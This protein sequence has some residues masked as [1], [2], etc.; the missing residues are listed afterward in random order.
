MAKKFYITTPI[1][2]A[3]GNLHIGH[4][5]SSTLAWVVRNFKKMQ[6][7]EA[8]MLTGS[9]EHGHKISRLAHQ[10][11]LDPQSFVDKNV[12]KFKILWQKFG[13][14]YDY[15]LRTTSQSHKNFVKKIFYKMHENNDIFQG[16]YQ[17][18]YS[19]SDEEFLSQVQCIEKNNEFFHPVSGAKMELVEENSYFFA[20]SKF[21]KW[22][23]N[24]LDAYPNFISDKKIANELRQNFFQKGLEDLSVSRKNLKWGINLEKFQDQTIYVWLDA[25]FSYLSIFDGQINID[26]PQTENF[27]NQA[28]EIVHVVGKEIARFHCIYWPIFL[29]SLNFRL[30]STIL[31]HGW[32]ITPEGKMSK[33]KGNVIN[34]LE[35]LDEFDPEIIK[36]YFV[37][38]ISTEND[39]IFDKKL[40]E[41]LYNSFFVNTYGNLISR[42]IALVLKYFN[43][44]LKFKIE[45]L[46][47]TDIS[48]YEKILLT[49]DSFSENLSNFQLEKGFK[50]IIELAKNLNGYFDIKQL[51]NEKNLDKLGASLLLVLNGIYTISACLNCVMPKTVGKIIDFLGIK[52]TSF[53]LITKLEKF[54][55]IIFEKLEKPFFPRKKS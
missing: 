24:Y 52:T 13:I 40:L 3:S 38:Q 49:F 18:L 23:E 33:S 19:V 37:S 30:P 9:D 11:G 17:G 50:L 48:Y 53:E 2:Y 15:F 51:W 41:S 54:D 16:Q 5:Y 47:W 22:L 35:L 43:N 10:S 6:G 27:W 8:L 55:N 21:Q 44:G 14:D 25:L 36:F 31:T 4:L 26:S 28:E 29:K 45:D 39:S 20:I 7:F 12:E 32:L 46:D 42:T 1:Y 34:P